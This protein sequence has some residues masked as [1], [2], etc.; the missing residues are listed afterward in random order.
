MFFAEWLDG[1]FC[2]YFAVIDYE[3]YI[4]SFRACGE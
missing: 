2:I 1:Q 4:C 3:I